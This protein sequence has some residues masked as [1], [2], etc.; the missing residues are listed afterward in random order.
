MIWRFYL[1]L[2]WVLT[3]VGLGSARAGPLA[4]FK[5]GPSLT[6]HGASLIYPLFISLSSFNHNFMFII[7]WFL[8]LKRCNKKFPDRS[9]PK[10]YTSL[11]LLLHMFILENLKSKLELLWVYTF[12]VSFNSQTKFDRPKFLFWINSNMI[13]QKIPTPFG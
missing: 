13:L 11:N 2:N 10:A 5:T 3:S 9:G 8:I 6:A 12:F 4:Y 1:C 7:N